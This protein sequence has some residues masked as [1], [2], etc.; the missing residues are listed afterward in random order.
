MTDLAVATPRTD[1]RII[2]VVGAA[3]FTS[4][5]F[6]LVL[7]PL[8]PMMRESLGVSYTELGLLMSMFFAG[9]GLFQVVAGFV[10][11]RIGAH[12]V[13]PAGMAVLAGSIMLMGFAPSLWMLFALALLAGIGNSVYHPADYS[14][15]TGRVTPSR[16]ARAYSVHSVSGTLGWA[17]APVTMIFFSSMFDWRMALS[18][19]GAIG[20]ICAAL[21]AMDRSDLVLPV[22][23]KH[24]EAVASGSNM[25][26]FMS[27]SILMAFVYFTLLSAAF[28]GLQNYLPTLLP[29]TQG[30]SLAFATTVTTFY[31]T[32][33]ACGSLAG[34]FVADRTKHHDRLIG[35]G[36]VPMVLLSLA[37]GYIA[38]PA[39]VLLVVAM[40]TGFLG[41]MT[42]PSRDMLVRAATPLGSA[43]KVFGF[44]YSGL[45]LGALIAPPAI[46]YMLDHG[47]VHGPFVFIALTI[48]ATL[49]PAFL[50]ARKR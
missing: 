16:M 7:P 23:K 37:M 5:F 6:Q 10:V 28:T 38:M 19:V 46:G 18:I 21:V 1:L 26:L 9:S 35:F 25:R 4:H 50:V 14:V 22:Q 12:V 3:H 24:V 48:L 17:A 33:Y 49:A 41:G 36:L 45:D 8:F 30:V 44:V 2:S 32:V 47:S 42:I 39:P 43:G 31:L 34:G 27:P 15:L 40:V 29:N 11:D 13:L 20:L